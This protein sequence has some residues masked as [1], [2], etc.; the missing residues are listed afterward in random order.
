MLAKK[1]MAI[2]I[3]EVLRHCTCLSG[4]LF[5]NLGDQSSAGTLTTGVD[6]ERIKSVGTLATILGTIWSPAVVMDCFTVIYH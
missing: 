5:Y 2:Q 1:L 6:G 4:K 3:Q